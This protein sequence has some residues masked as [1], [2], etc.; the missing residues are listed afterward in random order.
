LNQI[1]RE[2]NMNR[3]GSVMSAAQRMGAKIG[4]PPAS[5]VMYGSVHVPRGRQWRAGLDE[6]GLLKNDT[7]F[8][9]FRHFRYFKL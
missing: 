3:Y 6:A 1:G 2:F 9:N 7:N 4:G 5:P 8:L